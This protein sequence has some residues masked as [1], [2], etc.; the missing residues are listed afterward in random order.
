[1]ARSRLT[2][3]QQQT[4]LKQTVLIA[5]IALALLA[6]FIFVIMPNFIRLADGFLNGSSG[7]TQEEDQIPPQTPVLSA[8]VAATNSAQLPISGVG[9]AESQV[10]LV[11]NG[12][13]LDDKKID[14]EGK[15]NF[16][17]PLTEGQN[18]LSVYSVDDADN[19]SVQTREY[20]VTLDTKAPEIEVS[21][22]EDGSTIELRKNQITTI[23]GKT[24]PQAKVFI[25]ER[26]VYARAD[27][28]FSM[29]YKLEEGENTLKFKVQ[30]QANNVSEK[31]VKVA[32]HF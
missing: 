11:L 3:K 15:F 21:Q 25:N 27:G 7:L 26:L 14:D 24:E 31:E 13:R 17:V 5:G 8:P 30:D 10:V 23:V 16:E 19:E 4:M 12:E 22:P 18:S 20:Q 9:E 29:S 2:K 1:M 28:S 32:F 6:T